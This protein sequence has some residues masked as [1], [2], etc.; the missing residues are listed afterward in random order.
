MLRSCRSHEVERSTDMWID[1]TWLDSKEAVYLDKTG[2]PPPLA[3]LYL[4]PGTSHCLVIRIQHHQLRPW[5]LGVQEVG[6]A[7]GL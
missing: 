5:V 3:S 6:S 1:K 2:L 7:L 4:V